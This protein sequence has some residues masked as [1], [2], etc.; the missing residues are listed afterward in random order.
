MKHIQ[1]YQSFLNEN[2]NESA[3]PVFDAIPD[4][5]KGW[6]EYVAQH[7]DGEW[8]YY[9]SPPS[10]VNGVG[11]KN[12][13]RDGYQFASGIKTDSKDWNKKSYILDTKTGKIK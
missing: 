11:W 3:L 7:A 8:W 9:D 12:S 4:H 6:V 5:V 1:T 10:L 13:D 2:I